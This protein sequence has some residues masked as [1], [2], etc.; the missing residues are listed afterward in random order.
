MHVYMLMCGCRTKR[1]VLPVVSAAFREVK[2][3]AD[4]KTFGFAL[5]LLDRY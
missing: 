2:V 1:N 4:D 5:Q 3:S